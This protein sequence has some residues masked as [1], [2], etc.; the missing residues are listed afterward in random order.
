[1]L[2]I[3]F[4]LV[5]IIIWYG[6][7]AWW[8]FKRKGLDPTL[9]TYLT[10]LAYKNFWLSRMLLA[11]SVALSFIS[12]G[13]TIVAGGILA[14]SL[15]HILLLLLFNRTA[16]QPQIYYCM[17]IVICGVLLLDIHLG[18]IYVVALFITQELLY[19]NWRNSK[20]IR[21]N[22]WVA[23]NARRIHYAYHSLA[24]TMPAKD[25]FH[26]LHIAVTEDIARPPAVRIAERVYYLIKRPANIS[27]GIMQVQST[28][29]QSDLESMDAGAK[30]VRNILRKM[31]AKITDPKGQLTWIG[32][33]YNGSSTYSKYLLQ[34][35]AGVGLAWEKISPSL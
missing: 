33:Q 8:L 4:I 12:P 19:K 31:P 9:L 26:V 30:L 25:W 35:Y 5:G 28:I 23:G 20:N 14:L 29:P 7:G 10:P 17:L 13:F 22:R 27:T 16:T 21:Y 6:I 18:L 34:T 24:K 2:N 1:M 15:T 11:I 3:T 32:T